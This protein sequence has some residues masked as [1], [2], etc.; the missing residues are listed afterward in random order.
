[1]DNSKISLEA[2]TNEIENQLEAVKSDRDQQKKN[3]ISDILN[4]I[5]KNIEQV[6][7]REY[8]KLEN[9]KDKLQKKHYLVSC[10]EILL[11]NVNDHGYSLCRKNERIYLF[12]SE[13]WESINEEIFKDFLG[14]VSL[15]M[16]V[17][18]FDAK[19]HLFK[20][21]M[22]KQFLSDGGVK[23]IKSSNVTTLVNF[24]NGTFE[25]TPK[26]QFLRE[27]RK[28]DFLTYQL[29]FSYN[30]DSTAPRFQKFLDEVLP[31]NE[32]QEVLA[33]YL[34]YIF[35][36]NNVLKLEKVLILIG[37]GANGKS[38]LYEI[39][40]A[41]LGS[42]NVSGYSLQSLTA[43]NGNARAMIQNKLLNY[44]PE[45]SGKLKHN[46]F[47]TLISGE[48]VEAR[49]LYKNTQMIKG[50]ARFMFN[51]N[52]LPKEVD[53]TD[54]YF[55]RFMILPFRLTI[56][57]RNRD[58]ELAQKIINSEL[59]GVFNWVLVGLIR[60][61]ENK[62]FTISDIIEN[63]TLQY[64]KESDSVLMFLEDENYQKSVVINR[65][66]SELYSE[67][68]SYCKSSGFNPGS[69]KTFS[70]RLRKNGFIIKRKSYGNALYIEKRRDPRTEEEEIDIVSEITF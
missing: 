12:N 28:S 53:H 67:Y 22:Y 42:G 30:E 56:P 5:L 23:E 38:V 3:Q 17:D 6:N 59:S 40:L 43:E 48:E 36:K 60:L 2:I 11:N 69:I 41:L 33:E 65:P 21:E 47:K 70:N 39:I 9:D 57:L 29:P 54:G 62:K 16:G 52:E 51:C 37:S 64:Q 55:R 31:E 61:L 66:L 7:F 13:Y 58:P 27:F 46:I 1:M 8:C 34:G 24:D 35:I 26:K 68:D 20:D 4:E 14:N 49:L 50:Y 44:A 19:H 10:I 15:K 45:I 18:K 25:I 32:L 63:Q